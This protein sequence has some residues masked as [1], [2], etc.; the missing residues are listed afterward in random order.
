MATLKKFSRGLK[1]KAYEQEEVDVREATSNAAA[2]PDE[3]LVQKIKE[4]AKDPVKCH[5][6]ISIKCLACLL[7]LQLN[8]SLIK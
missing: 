6:I 2:W 1:N 3:N 7:K 4:A 5:K 8:F